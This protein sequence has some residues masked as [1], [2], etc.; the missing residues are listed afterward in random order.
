MWYNVLLSLS[1]RPLR[2]HTE[3]RC[4]V[5]E[6]RNIVNKSKEMLDVVYSLGL[7]P[8]RVTVHWMRP[9]GSD[10]GART[11]ASLPVFLMSLCH[12]RSVIC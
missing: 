1:N 2:K 8:L 6:G 5:Q 3:R 4:Y 12:E 7:V 11:V 10:W 9:L